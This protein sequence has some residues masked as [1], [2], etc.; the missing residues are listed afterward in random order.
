MLILFTLLA[1]TSCEDTFQ[2]SPYASISESNNKN[3][4]NENYLKLK[5]SISAQDT[6]S[7]SVIADS[8]YY[9]DNLNEVVGYINRD[10][11]SLFTVHVGDLSETGLLWEYKN[12]YSVINKL[13]NPYFVCIG[14]HDYLSN[15]SDIF[16]HYFG[17]KNF[18]INVGK[19]KFVFFDD[20]VWESDTHN[21]EFEWLE[22]EISSGKADTSVYVFTHIPPWTDQLAGEKEEIFKN[23]MRK[24]NVN[25]VITG[26]EHSYMVDDY[27]HDGVTYV[28]TGSVSKEHYIVVDV[29]GDDFSIKSIDY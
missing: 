11:K 28:T 8:H 6:F 18:T 3:L 5:N 2:Y 17:D 27:Y 7:F 23:M 9:Y 4:N 1:L 25:A 15:G 10:E 12:F 13:K 26:H 24:Y 19:N 20:V 29:K 16:H 22:N 21:P 14:N